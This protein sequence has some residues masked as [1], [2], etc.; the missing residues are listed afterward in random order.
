VK[1]R[2]ANNADLALP[3]TKKMPNGTRRTTKGRPDG[4]T[5]AGLRLI[6]VINAPSSDAS[7]NDASPGG[8][9]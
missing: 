2:F 1:I 6:R 3:I 5:G 9:K 8:T 7:P 4:T